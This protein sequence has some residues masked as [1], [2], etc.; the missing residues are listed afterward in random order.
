VLQSV[1]WVQRVDAEQRQRGALLRVHVDDAPLA[2][3]ELPQLVAQSGLTLRRYEQT[4]PS[5][6]DVF[7]QLVGQ[8]VQ[9]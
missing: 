3:R 6:E 2:K 1:S 7:V 9:P 4:L 5:L 8:E